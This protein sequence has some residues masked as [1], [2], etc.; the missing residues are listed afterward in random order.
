ME[1][2]FILRIEKSREDRTG[3][4]QY[5]GLTRAGL[6]QGKDVRVGAVRRLTGKLGLLKED[7]KS[8]EH[9]RGT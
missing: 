7:L 5:R 8:G 3:S 2:Y 9:Y 1:I 6:A 4:T